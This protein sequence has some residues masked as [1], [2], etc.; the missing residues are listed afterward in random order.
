MNVHGNWERGSEV[1]FL[2]IHKSDLICSVYRLIAYSCPYN[3]NGNSWDN[4][5]QEREYKRN[6][7]VDVRSPNHRSHLSN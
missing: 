3:C 2:G 5:V 7:R 4:S 6:S 1:S